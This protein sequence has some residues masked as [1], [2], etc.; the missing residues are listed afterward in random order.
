MSF[1]P[2]TS[3]WAP[4]TL[5]LIPTPLGEG[6]DPAD[7]LPV[8]TLTRLRSL[9]LL[10][11]ERA[12]SARAVL[13]GA[14]TEKPI[15]Q[16]EIVELNEHTPDSA[17]PGLLAPILAGRD[18]GLLSEA[19]CPAVADPGARLIALAHQAGVRV[20]PLVGPSSLLLA[21]MASGLNGQCFAFAGYLPQHADE[22]N[23]MIAALES[24]SRQY[25]E[26]QLFIE[27]PYRNQA[28]LDSLCQT[29]APDTLLTVASALTLPDETIATRPVETWRQKQVALPKVP[30][31]FAMLAAPRHTGSAGPGGRRPSQGSGSA[32]PSP[33]PRPG[34]ARQEPASRSASAKP[35]RG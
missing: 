15:Q 20:V 16:I 12:R 23:L 31:V 24:R 21:L 17:L 25:R 8:Q 6:S 30:T 32:K 33:H 34:S 5:W 7:V 3:S 26:T 2:E 11:A 14:G 13:K 27:T 29:L 22:R 10:I 18:A 28:L 9:E 19:G 35:R 1:L 4:G